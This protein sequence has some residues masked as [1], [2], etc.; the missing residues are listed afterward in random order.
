MPSEFPSYLA[1]LTLGA[2]IFVGLVGLA[3]L[4]VAS[5]RLGATD[6]RARGVVWLLA[7]ALVAWF[8]TALL[9]SMAGT[10]RAV[11][12]GPILPNIVYGI[13][14]PILLGTIFILSSKIFGR[15]L[16]AIPQ[17]LLVGIQFYRCL[18]VIFLVAHADGLLPAVFALP[19]G[20]GDIL[21]GITAL[22]VAY[23]CFR[24]TRGTRPALFAWNFIGIADLVLAVTLGFLSSPGR[25]QLLSFDAPNTM[26]SAYPLVLVP[27]FAVP[28][29]ILLHVAS[30]R[31]LRRGAMWAEGPQSQGVRLEYWHKQN[32][33]KI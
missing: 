32:L 11:V 1:P 23:L 7:T 25:F 14:L 18:G 31:K 22:V 33:S 12:A 15:L 21:V 6:G 28:L 30:L 3:G 5:A 4:F 20:Y 16:D 24:Q 17:H 10:F 8:T 2:V 29:S 13:S 26:A 9:F 19:T 27:V